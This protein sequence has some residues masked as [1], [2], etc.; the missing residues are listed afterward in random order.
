MVEVKREKK[1][2]S[3]LDRKYSWTVEINR[4]LIGGINGRLRLKA[5]MG[6]RARE[7]RESTNG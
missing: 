3:E 2:L 5:M 1:K 6:R 7:K 4:G